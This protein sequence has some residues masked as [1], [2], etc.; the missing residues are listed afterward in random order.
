MIGMPFLWWGLMSPRRDPYQRAILRSASRFACP[1]T[2]HLFCLIL[3]KL[4]GAVSYLTVEHLPGILSCF[5][6]IFSSDDQKD[7]CFAHS[8]LGM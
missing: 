7:F 3:I 5:Y 2:D 1:K 8:E 4:Y 6:N